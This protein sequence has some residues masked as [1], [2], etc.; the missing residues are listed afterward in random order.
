MTDKYKA[1]LIVIGDEVLRGQVQDANTIYL[2]KSLQK[3]GIQIRRVVVIPDEVDVIAKEVSE[4]SKNFP[5]VFTSGGVG[6]THDDVTYEGVAKGLGLTLKENKTVLELLKKAFPD[7]PEAKRMAV[8]PCPCEIVSVKRQGSDGEYSVIKANNVYILPGSP[9]YFR[10]GVDAIVPGLETGRRLHCEHVDVWLDEFEI[11]AVLEEQAL[12]WRGVVSIGSYPQ[13]Q[14]RKTRI[15]LEAENKEA[16]VK[17]KKEILQMLPI[18]FDRAKAEE[19]YRSREEFEHVRKA[20]D[21]LEECYSRYKAE[22]VFLSFNGGKDCTVVLHLAAAFVQMRN[23]KAPVCLYVTG[24][25]FPE[26]EEFVSE[27]ASYYGFETLHKDGSIREALVKILKDRPELKACLLGTRKGD[28]GAHL[29]EPF[30]HT[31]PGWPEIMRVSPIIE[32]SYNQVWQ[33]LL[34]HEVP[35]CSLYDEGYT[36]LGARATTLKNPLLRDPNDS[37]RYLPAH[38]L[39]DDSTERQGRG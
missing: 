1:A 38:S 11:V 6:P 14:K 31:D 23:L 35:Y 19:V 26:V 10:A 8:V 16:L 28:P 27:A 17:V 36:S 5:V 37:S 32:W 4:I 29:L 2:A 13:V 3:V 22:E 30:T 39:A 21:V 33:F 12:R 20:F 9:R 7:Q 34:R 18:G 15:T 24:D 25:A